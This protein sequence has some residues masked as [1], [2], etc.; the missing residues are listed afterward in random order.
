MTWKTVE[1]KDVAIINSG[2]SAPQDKKLFKSGDFNFY[3]TSDVGRIGI[4]EILISKDKLNDL[5]ILKLKKFEV[6]TILFPKSGASTFL[7]HRVILKKD[8]YVSSHLAGIKANNQ[9]LEDKYLFYFL[10]TIDSKNLV[11][12]SSY[13]SL[14]LSVIKKIKFLL[15]PLPIQQKIVAKLDKIFA[16]IDK[17]IAAVETNAENANRLFQVYLEKVF[18]TEFKKSKFKELESICKFLNGFAFKSGDS[19]KSSNTQ[20]LRM[21]N[22]YENNLDLDRRPIFYP[23]IY[24][25]KY[26]KYIVNVGDIV[27]SLTGTVGK[28]DYGYAVQIKDKLVNLLLNQRL[29]KIYQIDNSVVNAEYFNFFLHSYLFLHELYK[30]ANGTKQANLSSEYIKK[31]RIPLCSIAQQQTYV[32]TLKIIQNKCLLLKKILIQKKTNLT[33][34]K[35]SILFQAFNGELVKAA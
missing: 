2:N 30:S 35:Q 12:D 29:L 21:G 26:S 4:G 33:L 5:G 10:T 8:G 18:Y 28:Q 20:L 24:I 25:K 7:N 3:R 31:M 27:I 19:V 11:Q 34:L 15:P 23:D 22:L 13:P 9:L 14:N 17:S 16:E 6:G 32:N 1:L